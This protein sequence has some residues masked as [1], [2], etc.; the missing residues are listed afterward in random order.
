MVVVAALP[1]RQNVAV[2]SGRAKV[3]EEVVG[4]P[5]LPRQAEDVVV[6]DSTSAQEQSAGPFY[7]GKKSAVA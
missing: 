7:V 6:P 3:G 2:V 1:C 5:A 4:V